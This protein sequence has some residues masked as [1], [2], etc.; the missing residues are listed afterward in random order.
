MGN[1]YWESSRIALRDLT[2]K[3]AVLINQYGSVAGAEYSGD[4]GEDTPS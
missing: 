2:G 3:S 1:R 4:A